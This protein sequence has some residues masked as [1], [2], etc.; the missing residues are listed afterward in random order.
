MRPFPR[1]QPYFRIAPLPRPFL[2]RASSPCL[3]HW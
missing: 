3:E 1:G 2:P